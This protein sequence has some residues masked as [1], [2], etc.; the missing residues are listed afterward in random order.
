MSLE[1]ILRELEKA[2]MKE[3]VLERLVRAA[4]SSS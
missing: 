4:L 2:S 3:A 1:E